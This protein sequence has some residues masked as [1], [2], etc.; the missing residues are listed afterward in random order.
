MPVPSGPCFS[1]HSHS[2]YP[3]SVSLPYQEGMG[4]PQQAEGDRVQQQYEAESELEAAQG[5]KQRKP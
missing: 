2:L 3:H 4:A 5:F 1:Y